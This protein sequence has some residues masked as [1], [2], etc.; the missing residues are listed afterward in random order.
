MQAIITEC[1]RY[2]S[3]ARGTAGKAR[4]KARGNACGNV[5]GKARGKNVKATSKKLC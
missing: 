3:E 5:R 4:G 1:L 2:L